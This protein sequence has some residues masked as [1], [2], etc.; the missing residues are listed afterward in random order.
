[1]VELNHSIDLSCKEWQIK[2][3]GR[4]INGQ[5]QEQNLSDEKT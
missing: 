4:L 5:T 1:M 3:E 2:L